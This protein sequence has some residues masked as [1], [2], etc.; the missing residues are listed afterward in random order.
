MAGVC[1]TLPVVSLCC[2]LLLSPQHYLLSGASEF[3]HVLER[4]D[5]EGWR[6]GSTVW[7]FTSFFSNVLFPIVFPQHG[8]V[9]FW[10]EILSRSVVRLCLF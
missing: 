4:A 5:K 9:R 3:N 2:C 1:F 8:I 6:G 7:G 10:L